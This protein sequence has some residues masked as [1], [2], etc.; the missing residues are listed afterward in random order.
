MTPFWPFTLTWQWLRAHGCVVWISGGAVVNHAMEGGRG[1]APV[2]TTVGS[3]AV[4]TAF[5]HRVLFVFAP[6]LTQ[7]ISQAA[8][9]K[10]PGCA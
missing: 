7:L 4:T 6:D 2:W 9:A 1:D 5:T 3:R 8:L 10:F